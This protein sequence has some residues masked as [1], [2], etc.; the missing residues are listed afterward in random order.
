[1]ASKRGKKTMACIE[2]VCAHL[3]ELT[4]D[5][6]EEAKAAIHTATYAHFCAMVHAVEA[7]GKSVEQAVAHATTATK[8]SEETAA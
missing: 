6:D 1:M 8:T 4:Q 2:N 7:W 5:L 3:Q